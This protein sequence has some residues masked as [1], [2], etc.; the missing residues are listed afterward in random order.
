MGREVLGSV[1]NLPFAENFRNFMRIHTD[2]QDDVASLLM[3]NCLL[4]WESLSMKKNHAGL[5]YAMPAWV[6]VCRAQIR[7]VVC[8]PR[9]MDGKT[10]GCFVMGCEEKD[11]QSE[12]VWVTGIIFW[13]LF[14]CC[15][16]EKPKLTGSWDAVFYFFFFF[17]CGDV[18]VE[19][20]LYGKT[21]LTPTHSIRLCL[22]NTLSA[23]LIHMCSP[24]CELLHIYHDLVFL[25]LKGYQ[26]YLHVCS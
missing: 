19:D 3:W 8:G 13:V 25:T 7:I 18:H 1:A 12:L 26:A 20:F 5:W 6:C 23:D 16:R 21:A 24:K 22:E 14:S 9:T 17:F 11:L 2:F 15:S 10:L 4:L